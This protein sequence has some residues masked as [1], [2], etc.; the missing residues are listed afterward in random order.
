MRQVN[1]DYGVLDFEP[2]K[3][4]LQRVVRYVEKPVLDRMVSMGIYVMEPQALDFI[5]GSGY[6][7]FPHLVQKLLDVGA[8]VGAFPHDGLWLDIGRQEDFELAVALWEEGKLAS[9]WDDA[10]AHVAA[11]LSVVRRA[12]KPSRHASRTGVA[13]S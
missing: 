8:P 1:I 7:D 3:G 9:L 4:R 10:D 5:P 6:F 13:R 11:H 12:R 2:G